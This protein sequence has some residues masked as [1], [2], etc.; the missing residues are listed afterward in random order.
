MSKSYILLADDEIA[1]IDSLLNQLK[2][3][4]GTTYLY[5][6]T[7]TM[8]EAMEI[9][10]DLKNQGSKVALV[11]T[12]WLVPPTNSEDFI[13]NLATLLPATP[14]VML[15]GYADQASVERVSK[16]ANF[17]HFIRKP[18]DEEELLAVVRGILS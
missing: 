18:W 7:Q 13:A 9:A 10:Q 5:E 12:D 2:S 4:F 11:I 1:V 14:I 3:A 8:E 16:L 15:S 17:K 6:S